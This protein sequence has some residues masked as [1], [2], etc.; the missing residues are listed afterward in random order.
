MQSNPFSRPSAVLSLFCSILVLFLVSS[1]SQKQDTQNK[2]ETVTQASSGNVS[3]IADFQEQPNRSPEF[4]WKDA[5]GNSVKFEAARKKVTVV[6]FWA[7]WCGPCKHELP[8]LIALSKEYADRD[9]EFIGVSTDRGD[10]AISNVRNFVQQA[11]IPYQIVM[12]TDQLEEAFGNIRAIPQTFI[13]DKQ[14]NILK[15]FLGAR[16]KEFFAQAID[17]YL[18]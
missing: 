8:D 7:T 9:V 11:G 10:N 14:G 12:S 13:I 6:N 5:S 4:S 2:T 17:Q 18:Q 15:S 3:E 1:C 16:T